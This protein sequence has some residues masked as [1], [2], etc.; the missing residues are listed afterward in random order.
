MQMMMPVLR[1][2]P[3]DALL[4]GALCQERKDE[5][6]RTARRVSA[7]RKIA[8]VAGPDREDAQPV[9]G[10]TNC[11]RLPGHA[12]PYRRKTCDVDQ[13]EWD[14]GRVNDIVVDGFFGVI[15]GHAHR[16]SA[17]P[18][19]SRMPQAWHRR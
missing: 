1:S 7:V 16:W 4:R 11:E 19:Q 5:L 3:E 6:K 14:R 15:H 12:R 8:M 18:Q 13:D 10:H 9:Q 17:K 2:P